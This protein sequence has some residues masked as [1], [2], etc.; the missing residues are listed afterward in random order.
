MKRL[1]EGVEFQAQDLPG[2]VVGPDV[3]EISS[4][5][6][7]TGDNEEAQSLALLKYLYEN[8][9]MYSKIVNCFSDV[10]T[11]PVPVS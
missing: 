4:A 7:P 3:K 2:L 6:H 5:A 11:N 8:P 1:P 9:G 10:C